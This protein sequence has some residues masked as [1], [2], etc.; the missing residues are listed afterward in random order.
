MRNKK[1][2]KK[3]NKKMSERFQRDWDRGLSGTERNVLARA[4]WDAMNPP[5]MRV[6][7]Y[8]TAKG[9]EKTLPQFVQIFFFDGGTVHRKYTFTTSPEG[10]QVLMCWI[11]ANTYKTGIGLPS[12]GDTVALV[13][14]MAYGEWLIEGDNGVAQTPLRS[15]GFLVHKSTLS[16]DFRVAELIVTEIYC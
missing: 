3:H 5:H 2:T 8:E 14:A 7:T 1:Y 9:T 6:S 4:R 11:S 12:A 16:S 10:R 15:R 13:D